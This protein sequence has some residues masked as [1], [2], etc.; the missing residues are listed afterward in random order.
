LAAR[1]RL[2]C[3]SDDLVDG[4][5]GVRFE[6]EA[7]KIGANEAPALQGGRA[8]NALLAVADGGTPIPAFAVRHQGR[9]HAYLNRCG[10]IPVEL[11]WQRGQF[12]DGGGLYLICATHGA[13]YDPATGCCVGGRCNGRGLTALQ[14]TER[15]GTVYLLEG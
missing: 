9:V 2:I 7:E 6:L 5:P 1:E 10:H 13:L 3:A 4:G 11:D 12:F 15:E 14:V 8:R